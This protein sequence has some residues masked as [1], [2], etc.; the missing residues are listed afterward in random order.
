MN[1]GRTIL[2]LLIALSVAVLPAAGAGAAFVSAKTGGM[3]ATSDMPDCCPPDA[4]RC[5]QPAGNCGSMAACALKC[6][7]FSNI[8]LSII[9]FPVIA[10]TPRIRAADHSFRSQ[11]GS[12]PFRPP[13]S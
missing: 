13:R 10:A 2:A 7:G 11:P 4:N 5:D 1:L 6:F 9:A 3:S 12:A 8:P